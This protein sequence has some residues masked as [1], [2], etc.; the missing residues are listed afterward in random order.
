MNIFINMLSNILG[1]PPMQQGYPNQGQ[2]PLPPTSTQLRPAPAM[3][4]Q[5]GPPPT[6]GT[7]SFPQQQQ[8]PPQLPYPGGQPG[9]NAPPSGYPPNIQPG[10]GYPQQQQGMP[11]QYPNQPNLSGPP[12]MP[13]GQLNGAGGYPGQPPSVGP[14]QQPYR[15]QRIDADMIPNVVCIFL[16]ILSHFLCKTTFKIRLGSSSRVKSRKKS[17]TI[18]NQCTRLITTISCN[19]FRLSRSRQL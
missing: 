15:P 4:N 5:F 10:T 16:V 1:Q 17:R 13:G 7:P 8:Q 19:K 11:P 3:P 2:P 9:F 14:H 6:M 18:Y 12:T